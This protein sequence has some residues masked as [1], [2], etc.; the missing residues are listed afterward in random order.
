MLD[1]ASYTP[2]RP[3]HPFLCHVVF[4]AE[5]QPAFESAPLLCSMCICVCLYVCTGPFTFPDRWDQLSCLKRRR[6]KVRLFYAVCVY[7]YVCM[8]V[9][10][11][12]HCPTG[13]TSWAAKFAFESAPLLCCKCVCMQWPLH[14]NPTGGTS[15]APA[16]A[17]KCTP[18]T[19]RRTSRIQVITGRSLYRASV[20][21]TVMNAGN[22]WCLCVWNCMCICV[23]TCMR[24]CTY[25]CVCNLCVRVQVCI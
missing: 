12:S 13:G 11:P 16:S 14:I 6:L 17:W 7:V 23:Y 10:V 2:P 15:W 8:C 19:T 18:P 4:L 22:I 1:P 20:Q 3:F 24:V 21:G 5:L 9:L 25:V